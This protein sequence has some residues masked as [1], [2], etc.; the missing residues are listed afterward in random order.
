MSPT[1]ELA[2]TWINNEKPDPALW[3]TK[4]LLLVA[5]FNYLLMSTFVDV[6]LTKETYVGFLFQVNKRFEFMV[7]FGVSVIIYL[8]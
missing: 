1:N 8:R 2:E 7:P 4:W 5:K 6:Y 3:A